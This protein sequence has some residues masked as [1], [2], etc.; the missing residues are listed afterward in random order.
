MNKTLSEVWQDILDGRTSDAPAEAKKGLKDFLSKPVNPSAANLARLQSTL[1]NG[2]YSSYYV[3][4]II[5][6]LYDWIS[7]PSW[8]FQFSPAE[9]QKLIEGSPLIYLGDSNYAEWTKELS[10]RGWLE[11]DKRLW[12]RFFP[13][14]LGYRSQQPSHYPLNT[15]KSTP[16]DHQREVF[17]L[18]LTGY[19]KKGD[20]DRALKFALQASREHLDLDP[21]EKAWLFQH[22]ESESGPYFGG[23]LHNHIELLYAA[24]EELNALSKTLNWPVFMAHPIEDLK[25]FAQFDALNDDIR[26]GLLSLSPTVINYFDSYRSKFEALVQHFLKK[27]VWDELLAIKFMQYQSHS[28]NNLQIPGSLPLFLSSKLEQGGFS[29]PLYEATWDFHYILKSN[30]KIVPN[31][32]QILRQETLRRLDA[33]GMEASRE[34]LLMS[35]FHPLPIPG[36]HSPYHGLHPDQVRPFFQLIRAVADIDIIKIYRVEK[37]Y[38]VRFLLLGE[39]FDLHTGEGFGLG[40]LPGLNA[41]LYEKGIPYQLM[42]MEMT[43]FSPHARPNP[44]RPLNVVTLMDS[45]VFSELKDHVQP[46]YLPGFAKAANPVPVFLKNISELGALKEK[47]NEDVIDLKSD[48]KFAAIR[49]QLGKLEPLDAWTQLIQHC[50]RYPFDGKPPSAWQKEAQT[51]VNG[52]SPDQFR[53][54]LALVV[55]NLIKGDEWFSDEEKVCGLRGL[56]WLCRL[57]PDANQLYLLQK[58]ANRAYTKI[59]GGPLSSKLGNLALEGLAAIGTVQAFGA[60]SNLKAKAKYPV[61]VR[62]ITSAEKKFSGLLKQFPESELRDRVIPDHEMVGGQKKIPVG[63]YEAVLQIEGM[64]V[65]LSWLNDAGKAI[66]SVPAELRRDFAGEL[67]S[68]KVAA[69]SIEETLLA[70]KMRLENSWLEDRIWSFSLWQECFLSHALIGPMVKKLIWQ[71]KTATETVSFMPLGNGLADN[72]G[73][74]VSIPDAATIR[75]W[76][77]ALAGSVEE[78]VG[79]RNRLF[80]QHLVQPFRQAFREVYLLTPAEEATFDHSNRFAGHKLR[81]NTLYSLGKN[82]SWTMTYE[83]AP[84]RKLPEAGLTAELAINGRV[85]YDDCS[86]LALSFR[87][88]QPGLKEHQLYSQPRVP[89]AEVPPA[90]LSEIMRDVDLFVA[91]SSL[92]SDPYLGLNNTGPLLGYWREVAF[93]EKSKTSIADIRKDL[94]ERLLPM[95]K[96]AKQCKL[97]GNYLHVAGKIRSYKINL[98]SGN[99]LMEPNDQYLCI[100]QDSDPKVEKQIWLPFEGGDHI[101]TII[102]SKAFFLADDDKIT[103]SQILG[104]MSRGRG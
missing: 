97:E 80:E 1:E 32:E 9:F 67:Q 30:N 100:V 47:P 8:I 99:I 102:L 2:R 71:A 68:V 14:L 103:D 4:Q 98:G 24:G 77:P 26:I 69:K 39:Q 94:L 29:Q 79:W 96:I 61:Y 62:A 88:N 59:P 66:A 18:I 57:N 65:K 23:Q 35:G 78:V 43:F 36:N 17:L 25:A 28:G 95:T 45:V 7:K 27:M 93:G 10:E 92:G 37:L 87:K 42:V 41:L 15:L 44:Y 53:S 46:Q 48:P 101:L 50:L 16:E 70:Q 81:G 72:R 64:K 56:A 58:I 73:N 21:E 74:S 33:S 51:L 40:C 91:V 19:L 85:L 52:L 89:L 83:Q 75:L 31:L 3:P 38:R 12:F 5:K 13:L 11:G 34:A 54:G 49:E 20:F 22:I 104:Q 86:T 60:L 55:D 63:T 76:H 84:L 90:V 6:W 82:R